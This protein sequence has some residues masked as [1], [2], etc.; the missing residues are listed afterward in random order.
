VFGDPRSGDRSVRIDPG[1]WNTG[2]A[3]DGKAQATQIVALDGT[4]PA[5][6]SVSVIWL[7]QTPIYVE[8][9][10]LQEFICPAL[11]P[12]QGRAA[13]RTARCNRVLDAI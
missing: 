13:Q 4:A 8:L 5:T 11:V 6:R 12:L 2:T 9:L 1:A 3:R 7:G 10:R